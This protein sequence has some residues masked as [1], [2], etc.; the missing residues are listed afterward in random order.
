MNWQNG[1]MIV[2]MTVGAVLLQAL[3]L[4]DAA[5]FADPKAWAIAVGIQAVRQGAIAGLRWM[6]QQSELPELPA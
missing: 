3:A 4:L 1:V 5:V 2:L 6:A